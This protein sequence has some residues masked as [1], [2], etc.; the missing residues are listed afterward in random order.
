MQFIL[1]A[2]GQY[3]LIHQSF[4]SINEKGTEAGAATVLQIG[5]GAS[6]DPPKEFIANRPF[7]ILITEKKSGNILFM[8]TVMNPSQP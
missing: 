5:G 6:V 1:K 7:V 8:G 4:I 2:N 3:D